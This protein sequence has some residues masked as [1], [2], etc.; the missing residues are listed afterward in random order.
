MSTAVKT[1]LELWQGYLLADPERPQPH[2]GPEHEHEGPWQALEQVV[3]PC[4]RD[5]F[6]FMGSIRPTEQ[7]RAVVYR[8]KHKMTREYLNV[9]LAGGF[10]VFLRG[11]YHLIHRSDVHRLAIPVLTEVLRRALH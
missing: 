7:G 1:T 3:A 8:Y 10:Y 4:W 6:M 9:D 5:D 2:D 11:H